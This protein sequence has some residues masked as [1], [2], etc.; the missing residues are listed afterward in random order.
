MDRIP[1]TLTSE[2]LT[3]IVNGKS[4]V[5]QEGQPNFEPLRLAL[6]EERWN[7]VVGHLDV[8]KSITAWAKGNFS[9]EG[10]NV[11]YKGAT[12]PNEMNRRILEMAATGHDPMVICRFY[13]KLML[14][15]SKRSVDQLWSFLRHNGI[16]LS[17]DGCFL[18]YKGVSND[19]T[20]CHSH[21]FDNAP[22]NIHEM[23]R[24]RISDDP[25][26][27]CHEGFHVGAIGY[28]RTFGSRV[29][30]CKVSPEDV[31]CVPYDESAMKMRVCRYEVVG[32]YSGQL[33]DNA[34]DLN[35]ELEVSRPVK[36]EPKKLPVKAK[37]PVAESV[38]AKAKAKV[39]G[40]LNGMDE[41]ALMEQSLDT[42]RKYACHELGIVGASKMGGG[43]GTLVPRILKVRA[44]ATSP[45]RALHTMN[46][47]ELMGQ[48]MGILRKYARHD[49]EIIGA[50]K[51]PGGKVVLVQS[52][53]EVRDGNK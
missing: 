30:V 25:R 1:Y 53:L 36:A 51:L 17:E 14:N 38:V 22:G 32:H 39:S 45:Y 6:T 7:D 44:L 2:S 11:L 52:I 41:D 5:V 37:L 49:L 31:V 29:V 9:V 43:K 23:P 4:V 47:E 18:A 35:A 42:L 15:P 12:V 10:E 50:S 16:P 13:E 48:E 28:A 21:K 19:L 40:G 27:P 46:L 33:P 8:G 3:L 34:F 26:T 20:D 24:N